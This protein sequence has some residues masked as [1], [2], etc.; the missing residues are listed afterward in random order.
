MASSASDNSYQPPEDLKTRLKESYDAVA[1][2]YNA[3]TVAHATR[4]IEYLDKFLD[5]LLPSI[6][7]GAAQSPVKILEL[8]CGAGVPVM[9]KLLDLT[10]PPSSKKLHLIG[11]DLSTAQLNAARENLG[12]ENVEWVEGDMMS[13]SFPDTSLDAVLAFY[14]IIHLPREEQYLML[15]KI[16][17]WLKPGGLIL[18]NFSAEETGGEVLEQWFGHEKGWMFWSGWGSDKTLQQVRS[19][20]LEIIVGEVMPD[21]VTAKFLWVIAKKA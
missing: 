10:R 3:W 7:E 14:S 1:P 5:V 18:A 17:S 4:R 13:L 9:K 8:G 6:D 15:D 12:S 11:N 21:D 16:T 20:G 2:E 19:K